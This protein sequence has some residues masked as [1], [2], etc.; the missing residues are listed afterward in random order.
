MYIIYFE[1]P[2]FNVPFSSFRIANL[3][4]IKMGFYSLL[5][6]L[7][8]PLNHATISSFSAYN[9]HPTIVRVVFQ[10]KHNEMLE[11]NFKQ[12]FYRVAIKF[13]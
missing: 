6:S 8:L 1:C 4:Y 3:F 9:E 2:P 10:L 13:L 12:G 5:T 7:K 11:I